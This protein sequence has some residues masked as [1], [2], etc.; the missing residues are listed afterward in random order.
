LEELGRFGEH[1][2]RR[3][4]AAGLTQRQLAE[5]ARLSVGVVRDLEQGQ[6][7]RPRPDSIHRLTA[8]LG[9]ARHGNG[10]NYRGRTSR[11]DQASAADGGPGDQHPRLG[12]G[13]PRR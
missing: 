1:I 2:G 3:R 12:H 9:I 4:K 5:A 13:R 10:E 7:A 8:V 11:A 6:T